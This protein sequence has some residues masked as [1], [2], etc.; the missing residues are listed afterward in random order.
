MYT[1]I[2]IMNA[3][4]KHLIEAFRDKLPELQ[5]AAQEVQDSSA[6]FAEDIASF[7]AVGLKLADEVKQVLASDGMR[8]IVSDRAAAVIDRLQADNKP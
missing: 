8:G 3:V 7:L 6:E 4:A 2:Q 1:N 5:A